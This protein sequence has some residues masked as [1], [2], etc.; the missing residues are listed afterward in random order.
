M[1]V[2]LD[3]SIAD[4]SWAETIPDGA[5]VKAGRSN[6]ASIRIEDET[7]SS[8]HFQLENI[9]GGWVLKDLRSTNGTIVNGEKVSK[10]ALQEGD[11]IKAGNCTIVFHSGLVQTEKSTD[12]DARNISSRTE[13]VADEETQ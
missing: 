6:K 9:P 7:V 5:T 13:T 1:P 2:T 12:T 4:K 10:I 11:V 8:L 3:I